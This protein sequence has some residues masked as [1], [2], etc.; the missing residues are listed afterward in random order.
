MKKKIAS[1]ALALTLV[2]SVPAT[3]Y[4]AYIDFE[5]SLFVNLIIQQK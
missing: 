3:A 2:T 5:P 4:A 1:L